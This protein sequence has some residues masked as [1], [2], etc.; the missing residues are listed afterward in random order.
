MSEDDTVTGRSAGPQPQPSGAPAGEIPEPP[1]AEPPAPVVPPRGAP[2]APPPAEVGDPEVPPGATITPGEGDGPGLP[3]GEPPPGE[4]PPAEPPPAGWGLPPGGGA[5]R[6]GQP[7]R[8]TRRTDGQILGG[9]ANGLGSYFGIDPL[10][11]RV[12]F[13]V[14]ALAGGIG[15]ALYAALWFLVP[16]ATGAESVGPTVFRR[17]TARAWIG[18]ALLGVAALML[19]DAVGFQRPSIIWA[20]ALI[21]IG[22]LLFRQEAA[23]GPPPGRPTGPVGAGQAGPAG[24]PPAA[25]GD[26]PPAGWGAPSPAAWGGGA[27]STGWA[28]PP[29]AGPRPSPATWG[30]PPPGGWSRQP[31]SVLGL[32][33]LAVAVLAVGM[34]ALLD[35]LGLVEM[36]MGRSFALFLVVIGLGLMVGAWRG[37]S[38][39][40][41]VL[42]LLLVPTVAAASLA[43]VP[44]R[45]GVGERWYMPRSTAEV[46]PLYELGFGKLVVDL[47]D[48]RFGQDPTRIRASV[49]MGKVV[50]YVPRDVPVEAHGRASAGQV[51]LFD[52]VENGVQVESSQTSTGSER[53]GR[54]TL[55]L[56]AG[57]GAVQVVRWPP[58]EPPE[59]LEPKIP[60]PLEP[61]IPAQEVG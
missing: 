21:A 28:P 40:L 14:L 53:I 58:P 61:R 35:N 46:R 25:W 52:R 20:L 10:L 29:P 38:V 23:G 43:D 31:G 4:P 36:T 19:A 39:G 60:A 8:L 5:A 6:P 30:V 42:G 15:L 16:P 33:T 54:L 22:V 59:P 1:P 55:D 2:S 26:P 11:F 32:L 18:A 44:F 37:R 13:V 17:P 9:V 51:D 49:G 34:A 27:A 41:V 12:G 50:V 3:A 7:R 45:G 56:S 57:Y 47:R 48:V 24:G